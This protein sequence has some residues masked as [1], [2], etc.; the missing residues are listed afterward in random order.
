MTP[1]RVLQ[2]VTYVFTKYESGNTFTLQI[3]VI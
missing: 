1:E 3:L 2:N